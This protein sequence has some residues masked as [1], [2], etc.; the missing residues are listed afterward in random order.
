MGPAA[1]TS[2]QVQINALD[3]IAP[4]VSQDGMLCRIQPSILSPH[5]TL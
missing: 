2:D 4:A 3:T 1:P 5:R